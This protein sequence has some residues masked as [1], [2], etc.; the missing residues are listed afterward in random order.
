M[1]NILHVVNIYFVLPYFIG[2]QFFYFKKKGNKLHVIC[3]PSVHLAA[4]AD[5]MQFSYAEVEITRA[6]EPLKDLNAFITICKYIKKNNIDVM[7]G[8][9]PKGA[10]LAMLAAWVM[11]VPRR[12]YFRHG[13]VYETMHG[14]YKKLMINLERLTAFCATQVVCVSPSIYKRSLEDRLNSE[15]KQ[16]ILG[17]GTCG[18]IDA[19]NKFNPARLKQDQVINLKNILG[20]ENNTFVI[21]YCGRLVCDKGIAELV[22]AFDLLRK[23]LSEKKLKLLLVGGF[24]ERDTLPERI[25]Y[26]IKNDPDIIYTGFIFQNIEYYYALMDLFILPSYREGFGLAVLEASAMEL[27]VLTT[28]VT[29]C[30]DSIKDGIT[31][32]F[33]ANSAESISNGLK[34][35]INDSNAKK[36]GING[37]KFVLEYFDNRVL[38]PIIEKSLYN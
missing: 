16:L 36:Y 28:K 20:I 6:I 2:E 24:E 35:I 1:H 32:F 9:T 18:G 11:R 10:L 3:S 19:L 26:K 27:P 7:V 5:E 31:G 13:L 15:N 37:R 34:S 30:I 23:N 22:E 33:V 17:K 12:L 25:I 29:G 38:W 8:H 14:F 21:G 4:Y